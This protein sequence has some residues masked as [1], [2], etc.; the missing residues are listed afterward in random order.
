MLAPEYYNMD[1]NL[2]ITLVNVSVNRELTKDEKILQ[3]QLV[4]TLTLNA[5][6]QE[7][8]LTTIDQEQREKLYGTFRDSEPSPTDD[9]GSTKGRRRPRR[10]KS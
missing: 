9:V 2:Y 5:Q 3:S 4:R 8:V 7:N 1:M 10:P 6:V